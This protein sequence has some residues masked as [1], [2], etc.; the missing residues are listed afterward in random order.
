MGTSPLERRLC[1]NIRP[2]TTQGRSP[3]E[4]REEAIGA[5]AVQS[6]EAGGLGAGASQGV[7]QLLHNTVHPSI[8]GV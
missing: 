2:A 6:R 3:R 7:K 5:L 8:Q 1:G 4:P